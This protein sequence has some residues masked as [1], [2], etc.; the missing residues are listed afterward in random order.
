MSA[1]AFLDTSVIVYAFDT[2][3]PDKQAIARRILERDGLVTSAQVLGELYV[4][5]TRKIP[6]GLPTGGAQQVIEKL[7]TRPNVDISTDLVAAAIQTSI[8]FQLSYWDAL[9]I[10]A[11][12]AGGC[13]TLLTEDLN[14]G[15]TINGV[16][17]VNPFTATDEYS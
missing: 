11:A 8:R 14:D 2:S 6:N 3:A 1:D 5:L 16:R 12:V 7:R 10:E 17:I 13:T 15:E 4:T 9:I